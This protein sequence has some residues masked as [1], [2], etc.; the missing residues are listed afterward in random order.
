[1]ITFS[2]HTGKVTALGF[3]PDGTRL[4]SVS[5]D[6]ALKLW[7]VSRLGSSPPVWEVIDAHELP[8]NHCQFAWSGAVVY[9]GGSDGI[10][11]AWDA[12]DGRL[13]AE[14]D[15]QTHPEAESNSVN[16]FG[17]S[18]C[19]NFVAYGGGYMWLP[20]EFVVARTSDLT[21]IRRVP[22]HAGAVGIFV[23][24]ERG[25]ITGSADQTV[26]LWDWDSTECHG[27]IHLRGVVRGLAGSRDGKHIA[28]CG[29]AIVHRYSARPVAGPGYH[30]PEKIGDFR[31]HT[32]RVDCIEFS[33]DG[34]RLA[35]AAND[36]TVRV[37]DVAS[38]GQLRAFHPKLGPLHW[39]TFAPDGL[40]LAFSSQKGHIGLLD[41]DA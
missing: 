8:I 12:R 20:T 21:P 22:G 14:T 10:L 36:G 27:K 4:A 39:V 24:Q 7:D 17:L 6:G 19:G 34:T 18:L 28:S 9:T 41:M 30:D 35:S 16:A 37:W 29:G 13:V 40:T 23:P 26:R 38:G 2:P 1:M 15:P 32:K 11:K 5:S 31:G 33:P 25:F 3:S